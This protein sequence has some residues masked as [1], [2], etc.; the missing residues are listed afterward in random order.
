MLKLITK[1]AA[2]LIGLSAAIATGLS[3][4]AQ[5]AR[6]RSE[7]MP[8]IRKDLL[9]ALIGD[10]SVGRVEIK[11]IDFAPAQKA[12][13]HRHPSPVVGYVARG[14]ILFQVEGNPPKL[15]PAGS[16]FFEPAD[17]KIV[18]FDNASPQDPAT[19]IAFY[20]LG[21]DDQKLIEMLE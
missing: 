9:T 14:S 15:L 1:S 17:S 20:L 16:A 7:Q 13:L 21:K 12:G 18:R 6:P 5:E 10:K 4:T 8:I 11:Q 2:L 19:F 3:V